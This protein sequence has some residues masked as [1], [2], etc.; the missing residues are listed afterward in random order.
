METCCRS[1]VELFN[2]K[3]ETREGPLDWRFLKELNVS[4]SLLN[5]YNSVLW[6]FTPKAVISRAHGLAKWACDRSIRYSFRFGEQ[7]FLLGNLM[8]RGAKNLKKKKMQMAL[9]CVKQGLV[10]ISVVFY[11][12]HNMMTDDTSMAASLFMQGQY[13]GGFSFC[14]VIMFTNILA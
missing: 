2:R 11:L 12:I 9:I 13:N 8:N 10:L 5:F 4:D 3:E 1:I 14:G 6:R 7:F